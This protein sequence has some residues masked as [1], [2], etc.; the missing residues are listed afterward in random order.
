MTF[1]EDAVTPNGAPDGG[2]NIE[3]VN[4]HDEFEDGYWVVGL[5]S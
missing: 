2:E 4:N 3:P 1:C 5:G